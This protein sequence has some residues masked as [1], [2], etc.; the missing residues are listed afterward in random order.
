MT[1]TVAL[2]TNKKSD[3]YDISYIITHTYFFNIAEW[4]SLY[5]SST[6]NLQQL[7]IK[8]LSLTCSTCGCEHN[9]SV[10]EQIHTKRRNRLAQK[11]LNDLVFVKYNQKMKARYNK[12]DVI[13]P[14]SL[15]DID[16]SNE[17]LLGEMGAK[18]SM[19][20]EDELVFD[21]GLT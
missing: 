20:V 12:R 17:W 1:R 21:D 15:D 6:P 9:W 8:I 10:F 16:E 19:N 11:R 4:W 5:G 7:A 3:F 13:D 18:P 2:F 14:I